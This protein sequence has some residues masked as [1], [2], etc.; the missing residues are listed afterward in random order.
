MLSLSHIFSLWSDSWQWTCQKIFCDYE[1]LKD[2]PHH[3]IWVKATLFLSDQ[4]LI[5]HDLA[6]FNLSSAQ[7][8]YEE[9]FYTVLPE[10]RSYY[11]L[12]YYATQ[13]EKLHQE[14]DNFTKSWE[15]ACLSTRCQKMIQSY[16]DEITAALTYAEQRLETEK[17]FALPV[18]M[19]ALYKALDYDPRTYFIMRRNENCLAGNRL[20]RALLCSESDELSAVIFHVDTMTGLKSQQR[21]TQN[22]AVN[23]ADSN[24]PPIQ[25]CGQ[26]DSSPK[27]H[28][29][30]YNL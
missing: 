17:E 21:Q 10:Q 1:R 29:R 13:L 18:I 2:L 20:F 24:K 23:T 3:E 28:A 6:L 11:L 12:Q 9:C 4:W 30:N 14:Y 27:S 15:Y 5:E 22:Q 16:C 19:S 8:F 7:T 26:K 25:F